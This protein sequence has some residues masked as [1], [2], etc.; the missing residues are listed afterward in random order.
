MPSYCNLEWE[1]LNL[2][3]RPLG[4]RACP[5]F[6]WLPYF[7]GSRPKFTVTIDASSDVADP[8]VAWLVFC[9][10]GSANEE[11]IQ[12]LSTEEQP[13][14]RIEETV[15]LDPI[16]SSGDYVVQVQLKSKNTVL[17]DLVTFNALAKQVALMALFAALAGVCVGVIIAS[18][19][20]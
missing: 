17:H 6:R 9:G 11:R 7:T 4:I 12:A 15:V 20:V 5:L 3:A 16:A 19:I 10:P 1:G 18:L 14:N 13:A 2:R 8:I